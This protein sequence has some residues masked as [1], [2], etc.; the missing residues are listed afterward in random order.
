MKV[1]KKFSSLLVI[2]ALTFLSVN[3]SDN[4]SSTDKQGELEV[5]MTYSPN[6]AVVNTPIEITFEVEEGGEHKAVE[7]F[8]SE[9]EKEGTGN[10]VKMEMNAVE[11][12]A[13]HYRGEYTFTGAGHYEVHFKFMYDMLQ[14]EKTF[15]IE[16]Q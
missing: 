10:H 3:C 2:V 12:E 15:E 6:P 13:G 16:V 5:T 7:E 9:I 1:L 4:P 8:E 11:N 14:N